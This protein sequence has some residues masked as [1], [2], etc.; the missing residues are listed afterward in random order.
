MPFQESDLSDVQDLSFAS[1]SEIYARCRMQFGTQLMG[2]IADNEGRY[3]NLAFI[4]SDQNPYTVNI[5]DYSDSAGAVFSESISGSIFWQI[6]SA[7]EVLRISS[8]TGRY[9]LSALNEAFINAIAHR[10]Y[11]FDNAIDISVY[12]DRIEI[13]SPYRQVAQKDFNSESLR[14]PALAAVLC[15]LG[16]MRLNNTGLK[17]I[18]EQYANYSHKPVIKTTESSFIVLLPSLY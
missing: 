4:L 8:K 14:N 17:L 7:F 1:A 3:L 15:S 2:F 9:P 12:S 16:Y 13:A 18:Y 10:S 11:D 5:A 6:Q